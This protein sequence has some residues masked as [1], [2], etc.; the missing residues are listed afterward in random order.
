M[1]KVTFDA[2][3]EKVADRWSRYI[4][5]MGIDAVRKQ[6]KACVLLIGMNSLGLEIAKNIILSGV[7]KITLADWENLQLSD[8]LSNFYVN[9]GD[10]GNNRAAVVK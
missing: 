9:E 8:C 1:Q 3:D 2:S 5:A 4:G 7:K 6:T 10:I